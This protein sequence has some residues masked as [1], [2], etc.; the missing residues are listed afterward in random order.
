MSL[1]AA[2]KHKSFVPIHDAI[3]AGISNLTKWYHKVDN[4]HVYAMSSSMLNQVTWTH[5]TKETKA[6]RLAL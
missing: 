4:C 6:Q 5:S 1:E 2:K 3:T